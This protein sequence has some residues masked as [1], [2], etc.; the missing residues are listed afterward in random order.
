[1][2]ASE[3]RLGNPDRGCRLRRRLSM[4]T[5]SVVILTVATGFL[6]HADF[7]YSTV[8]AQAN[9]GPTVK[10]YFKGSRM[11]VDS[12][13]SVTIVD[14]DAKTFTTINGSAK[15]YSVSPFSTITQAEQ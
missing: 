1:M 12:G 14:F 4:K 11:K 10:Y 3:F 2:S 13:E 5:A 9:S 7:S 6:A 15:T 8:P